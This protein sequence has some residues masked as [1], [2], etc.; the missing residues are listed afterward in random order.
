MQQIYKEDHYK[1]KAIK[2]IANCVSLIGR[3]R[4]NKN[5]EKIKRDLIYEV[6]DIIKYHCV[7]IVQ[8]NPY[9]LTTN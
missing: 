4:L 6:C 8:D 9:N 7:R 3:Y 1:T 2:G 5:K